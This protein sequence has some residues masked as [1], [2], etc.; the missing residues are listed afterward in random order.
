MLFKTCIFFFCGTK[1][2]FWRMSQWFSYTQQGPKFLF[3]KPYRFVMTLGLKKWYDRFH[4][5]VNDPF[6]R[7]KGFRHL[8]WN[9]F[10]G[11]G[12]HWECQLCRLLVLRCDERLDF[13]QHHT[14]MYY[15]VGNKRWIFSPDHHPFALITSVRRLWGCSPVHESKAL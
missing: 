6:K 5:Q 14:T 9:I 12:L 10:Q 8:H 1:K 4:F 15:S 13:P 3:F 11:H 2:T 7:G